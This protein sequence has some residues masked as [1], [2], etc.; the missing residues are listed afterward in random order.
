MGAGLRYVFSRDFSLNVDLARVNNAGT[1]THGKAGRLECP[2]ERLAGVLKKNTRS[3][4]M[5]TMH[6]NLHSRKLRLS[7]LASALLVACATQAF[8]QALPAGALPTG[9]NVTS[10]SAPSRAT[11]TR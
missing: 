7:L 3:I 6:S 10:G 1:S 4:T 8:A 2:P 11:A 9:W 5:I